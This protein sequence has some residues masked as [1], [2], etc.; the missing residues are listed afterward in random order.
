M[1][2]VDSQN[3]NEEFNDRVY[4]NFTRY[5]DWITFKENK[6]QLRTKKSHSRASLSRHNLKLNSASS[7]CKVDKKWNQFKFLV[8]GLLF[9]YRMHS[10]KMA[11]TLCCRCQP[12]TRNAQRYSALVTRSLFFFWGRNK[13]NKQTNKPK[14]V[15]SK[16]KLEFDFTSMNYL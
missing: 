8:A 16:C 7:L 15:P 5:C 11:L 4:F 14:I 10:T 2:T 13:T 9:F 12:L 1:T 6:N 3:F